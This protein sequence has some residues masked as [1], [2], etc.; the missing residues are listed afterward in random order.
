MHWMAAGALACAMMGCGTAKHDAALPPVVQRAQTLGDSLAAA[1]PPGADLLLEIDLARLRENSVVGKLLE[2]SSNP[3]MLGQVDVLQHADALLILV[4]GIGDTPRQ[5]VVLR[6]SEADLPGATRLR[7]G[8][9]AVGDSRLLAQAEA[10]Q[11]GDPSMA[12]DRQL[13]RLRA[14]VMPEKARHAS[15]RLAVRL[16]FDARVEVAA[17]AKVSEVPVSMALW[18]DVEDDLAIVMELQTDKDRGTERM[19]QAISALA[20]RLSAHPYIR[21]LGLSKPIQNAR[22]TRTATSV[23]VVLV[24]APKRLTFLVHRLL[25]QFT[26]VTP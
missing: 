26:K 5:L 20:K 16:N 9:F 11:K 13:Q 25:Q 23:R 3:S 19:A 22:V 6:S 8:L 17:K 2:K 10:L 7:P 1:A 4:Y 15:V 24:I 12:E 21:Y 18:G 14:Q